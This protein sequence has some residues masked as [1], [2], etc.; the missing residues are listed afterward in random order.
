MLMCE[1]LSF[2]GI[3]GILHRQSKCGLSEG[4]L[5]TVRNPCQLPHPQQQC[6]CFWRTHLS[7]TTVNV[8]PLYLWWHL[9][10][11]AYM[12]MMIMTC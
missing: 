11:L 12:M 10:T 5:G 6:R 2:L 4:S 3:C 9:R 7:L 1:C 8:S